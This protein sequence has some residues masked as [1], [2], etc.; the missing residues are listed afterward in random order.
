[1]KI[2]SLIFATSNEDKI[3]EAESIL[4][5]K[6]K[7]TSF[8]V[9]E[10]QSLDPAKVAFAKAKA[11]FKVLKTPLF[12]EDTS[13]A[14]EG[15]NG[16]PGT[17]V[18]DVTKVLDNA[19]LASL[20]SGKSRKAMAQVTI[21]FVDSNLKEH[22]FVGKTYGTIAVSPKGDKGFGWDPIFIPKGQKQTFAEMDLNIKNKYSMR[23]KAFVAFR[24]WLSS[25]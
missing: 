4:G 17:Y 16:L 6:V 21:V 5:I 2:G 13:L 12:V 9:E 15:L 22:L 24:K 23:R 20:I 8:E 14:I 3:N 11:Y 1:M 25:Q 19:G 7:G 10:I 18:N